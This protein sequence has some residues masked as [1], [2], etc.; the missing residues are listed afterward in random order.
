MTNNPFEIIW[1]PAARKALAKL[2]EK[3]G[4]AAIELIYGPVADNPHR[5]S[6][7]L[8]LGLETIR[9][10]RRGDYRVLYRVDNDAHTV[11]IVTIEHRADAYRRR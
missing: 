11:D 4:T 9:A 2:P 8:T 3:V 10:A 6:K 5:L 1:S 7:P